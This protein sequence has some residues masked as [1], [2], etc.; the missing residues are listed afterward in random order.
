M[1]THDDGG[2]GAGR[3]ARA[4]RRA[5]LPRHRHPAA[6]R[7]GRP[8]LGLALP[9]HGHQGGAAGR[10]HAHQPDPAAST[11]GEAIAGD[12]RPAARAA[13]R[14]GRAARAHPR[15]PRRSRPGSSTTRSARSPPG[16]APRSSRCATATRSCGRRR[17]DEGV[18]RGDFQVGR[19]GRRTPGAAGDVQRGRALVDA[20]RRRSTSTPWPGSTPRS[21]C[22]SSAPESVR[23]TL[24]RRVGRATRRTGEIFAS[25]SGRRLPV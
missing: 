22:G 24:S 21:R 20:R 3:R 13:G 2:A 14:P 5:R 1:S 11:A 10:H 15:R 16:P 9:L 25:I 8:V 7:R 19:S 6:R 12:R 4:L 17:I 23:E 18:A